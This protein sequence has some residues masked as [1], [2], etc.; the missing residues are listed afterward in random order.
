MGRNSKYY[1]IRFDPRSQNFGFHMIARSQTIAED[2]EHG[3]IF[4]DRLRSS[5]I[6]IAGSQTI[7]EVRF[8]MIG[9]DRRTFCNPYPRLSAIIWKPALSRI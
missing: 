7:A 1:A 9:D 6:T 4:C 3:S 5:A 8:H 2:R